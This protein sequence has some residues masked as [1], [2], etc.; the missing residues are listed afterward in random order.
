[1]NAITCTFRI[2]RVH[3]CSPLSL[4]GT[5][6]SVT[7]EAFGTYQDTDFPAMGMS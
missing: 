4:R 5:G 1:M 7:N 3:E 2:P 6:K